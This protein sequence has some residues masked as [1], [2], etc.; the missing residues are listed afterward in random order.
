MDQNILSMYDTLYQLNDEESHTVLFNGLYG[1]LDIVTDEEAALIKNGQ[2]DRL[3]TETQTRLKG[4]GHLVRAEEDEAENAAI[5][6]RIHW[7]VPYTKFVDIVVLPTYNCNFRCSYCFE[8]FRLEKGQKW[9]AHKMTDETAEAIIGQLEAMKKRGIVIRSIIL[10]GGEPLLPANKDAVKKWIDYCA[11]TGTP[12]SCVSNGY[13][14]EHFL[15][16][17]KENPPKHI[18]ITVD[19]LADV[20][21]RRRF[22]AGGDGSF[23]KIMENIKKAIDQGIK[24]NVRTNINRANLQSSMQLRDEYIKR[25]FTEN[26]D[27]SWY[28]K[29]TIGCYEEDPENAITDEELYR[30]MLHAGFSTEEAVAHCRYYTAAAEAIQYII[31]GEGYPKLRPAFCG[32]NSDMITIDPDGILYTC[33]DMVSMEENSVGFLDT[34]KQKFIYNF[35]F[36]KWRNR[37][38]DKIE[39]CRTCPYIMFCGGGCA[40]EAKNINGELMSGICGD[41]KAIYEEMLPM[42][43]GKAFQEKGEYSLGLSWYE[44]FRNLNEE[45][46][47]TLLITTDSNQAWQ[48]VRG[49]MSGSERIFS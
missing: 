22:L 2:Y 45:K 20:H 7:L 44:L 30:E 18:Q 10:F 31:K 48:I 27:F 34:E 5:I 1:A 26:P 33:W 40:N 42:L 46:R 15:G 23:Q 24:I 16:M 37:T 17:M 29:A 47:K 8:R 41:T 12:Y 28:F 11:R 9:L 19:G 3:S 25:G 36:A 38:A 4:R 6:S 49:C 14:L 39:K 13:E 43:A 21:D 32:A 35:D